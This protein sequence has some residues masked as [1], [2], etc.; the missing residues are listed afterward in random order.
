MSGSVRA[1]GDLASNH[2]GSEASTFTYLTR[3]DVSCIII[4]SIR[5]IF[6]SV[7]HVAARYVRVFF[8]VSVVVVVVPL[9]ALTNRNIRLR[10]GQ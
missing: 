8:H 9:R 6:L 1:Q 2:F 3:A 7:S 4:I 5:V 10:G